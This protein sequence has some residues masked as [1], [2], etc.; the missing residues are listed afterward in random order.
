VG[1][2]NILEGCIQSL[3]RAGIDEKLLCEPVYGDQQSEV[4][5]CVTIHTE[6][7]NIG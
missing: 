7:L 4:M 3:D 6:G 5:Q 2:G 1:N